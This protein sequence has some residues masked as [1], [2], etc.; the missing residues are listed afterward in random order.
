SWWPC[1]SVGASRW[2]PVRP[3][4]RGAWPAAWGAGGGGAGRLH[5]QYLPDELWVDK[6]GL[7]PATLS[8][9]EAKGHKVRRVD[10]WGDAEA[11][12]SDP[13]THLRYSSSDPRNEGAATGQD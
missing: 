9:L 1:P 4:G 8:V 6:W 3:S 12:Y 11:V 10:A 7:E 13:R 2:R 5:H